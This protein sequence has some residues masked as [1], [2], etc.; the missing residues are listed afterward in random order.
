MGIQPSSCGTGFSIDQRR[1][2][3]PYFEF[4][5]VVLIFSRD[6]SGSPRNFEYRTCSVTLVTVIRSALERDVV[7]TSGIVS[8]L[9][10]EHAWLLGRVGTRHTLSWT[11][12]EH[13]DVCTL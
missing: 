10:P 11:V 4:E 12:Q 6:Q 5:A 2:G 9:F 1:V 13:L 3:L 8:C 7:I